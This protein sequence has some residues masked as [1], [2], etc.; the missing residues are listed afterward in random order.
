MDV[1]VTHTNADFDACAS[2]V[3]AGRLYPEAALV[4]PG[5]PE[6]A[7]RDYLAERGAAWKF[8]RERRVRPE[9]VS[10][11]IM[12]D[13][14][15]PERIG[16]LEAVLSRPSVPVHVYDH[17]PQLDVPYSPEVWVNEEVGSTISILVRLMRERGMD[18]SPEEATLFALGLRQDTG[19]LTFP[20]TAELDRVT[21]DYLVSRGADADVVERYVSRELRPDQIEVLSQLLH[22]TE[23]HHFGRVSVMVATA[24]VPSYVPDVAILAH[25]LRDLRLHD[26]VFILVQMGRR[27]QMVA[28]SR[29]EDLDVGEVARA[30]GGGGHTTAASAHVRDVGL[31]QA[32]DDLIAAVR[33][34]MS[35]GRLR[36]VG[37]AVAPP[38]PEDLASDNVA[39][40]MREALP[41]DAAELL[42]SI[43]E[44][45]AS[46]GD[47][48]YVVGGFVRDLLLGRPNLDIDVVSVRDGIELGRAINGLMGGSLRIHERF[49][50]S[51]VYLPGG[52]QVDVATAR[53]EYYERPG[54]LP[55]VALGGIGADL[56]RRDFAVN[57]MAVCLTPGYY[58]ALID[59]HGGRSD[60]SAGVIRVLHDLSFVEDPVRILR[61]VRFEMRLGFRCEP[62]TEELIRSSCAV[63]LHGHVP[64]A[65]LWEELRDLLSDSGPRRALLRM[66][67]LGELSVFHPDLTPAPEIEALLL[68]VE[69][70]LTWWRGFASLPCLWRVWLAAVT[71][72]LPPEGVREVALRYH[73]AKEAR[74]SLVRCRY[75]PEGAAELLSA[76]APPAASALYGALS[77]Y[78]DE[79]LLLL[80][81]LCPGRRA[82]ARIRRFVSRLRPTLP[83]V[84]GH[85]LR[86][87]GYADGRHIGCVLRRMHM[88]QLDGLLPT[89]EAQLDWALD[90]LRR[91]E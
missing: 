89:R 65:R 2:L 7:V 6:R 30:L 17:H 64:A 44:V 33:S 91:G 26:A 87:M 29:S 76:E 49:A 60:L 3:A 48:A 20:T 90:T 59:L 19:G 58:G 55:E 39:D 56:G 79:E 71:H 50:T 40:L 51:S 74:H 83:L 14:C 1:V 36:G 10:R 23:V 32:H 35:G 31:L 78:C 4:F 38:S 9:A 15:L 37:G 47:T 13:V 18:I 5:S 63:D 8:T 80:A 62:H 73:L 61:A 28:R 52:V 12:V 67:E 21:Y 45:A 81:A 72:G 82:K 54:A 68:S 41:A 11:L 22:A 69:K 75:L 88:L 85:E 24:L 16:K 25:Q 27:I 66:A 43:G 42:R 77:R 70:S 86:E 84:S 46:V 53:R 57:A 34:H